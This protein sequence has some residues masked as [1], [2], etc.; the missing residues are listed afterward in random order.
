MTVSRYLD[1]D[2][3]KPLGMTIRSGRSSVLAIGMFA[4]FAHASAEI[5]IW[6]GDLQ[7]VGR[8]GY[9]QD[10]FN[11]L[12]DVEDPDSLISIT[13]QVGEAVPVE[14]NFHSYRRI[15]R[16]GD[17]NADIP[18]SSLD[19]GDNSIKIRARIRD[20]GKV[21]QSVTVRKIAERESTP[22]A[23]HWS[24]PSD[25]QRFGQ[26]VDGKWR[27]AETGIRTEE[28]GYDRLYLV[29]EKD[30]RDYELETEVI[31]HKIDPLTGPL[32]G[33]AGLGVIMRFAGHV[34]GGPH[35]FPQS[36]P[37]W[38]FQPFGS[39]CWLR[40]SKNNP[41]VPPQMQ[42]Y[43]GDSLK[44][45]DQGSFD[46]EPGCPYIMK[47]RCETLPDKGDL[48]VSLYFFKIWKAGESEPIDWNWTATQ[49]SATALRAGGFALVAH[50]VDASF[51]SLKIRRLPSK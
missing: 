27:V 37:K 17:F 3:E 11:L 5:N 4:L 29:G 14:M 45:V 6:Y 32:S 19:V 42:F 24:A 33:G 18:L 48:G 23:I 40:W 51:Q 38:G 44:R 15:A 26:V 13:Y 10:D 41:D 25:L 47:I 30:W 21:E 36:Q 28:T 31:L 49:E 20:G 7:E 8:H 43:R 46:I 1:K 12:G 16:L 9:S 39:I 50:H 34:V 35:N 22:S 2:K